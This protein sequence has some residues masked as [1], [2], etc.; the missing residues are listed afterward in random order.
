MWIN[1]WLAQPTVWLHPLKA[2]I[3]GRGSPVWS[4]QG[5]PIWTN[6]GLLRNGEKF[7]FFFFKGEMRCV[8]WI[9][10]PMWHPLVPEFS[11]ILFPH[12]IPNLPTDLHLGFCPT[13]YFPSHPYLRTFL[14]HHLPEDTTTTVTE[15]TRLLDRRERER[16]A[17]DHAVLRKD[18]EEE[19]GLP[20]KI[21]SSQTTL[22][23]MEKANGEISL[24]EQVKKL[25][26]SLLHIY[27]LFLW[28]WEV[29]IFDF[30]P[31]PRWFTGLERCGKSCRLRWL[32]YLRPGIKRGNITHVEEDLI[33]RLHRLLGNR[34]IYLSFP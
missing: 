5:N 23:P 9:F 18:L 27:F 19:H 34:S 24:G 1:L 3:T 8:D 22:P 13:V 26:L 33:I 30:H 7:L 11:G 29:S 25:Q 21:E 2:H 16:W 32:N 14:M 4:K 20:V 10:S 28:C 6:Q 17:G 12:I 31:N 15:V